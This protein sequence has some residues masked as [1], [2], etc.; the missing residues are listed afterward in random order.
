VTLEDDLNNKPYMFPPTCDGSYPC[1]TY[2]RSKGSVKTCTLKPHSN[3]LL[4]SNMVT[5]T[6]SVDGWA[7]TFGTARRDLGG[8]RPR[9]VSFS[10]YQT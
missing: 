2:G 5:G 10:L 6:L 8:L 4:Y 1:F 9:L 3:G 7:V